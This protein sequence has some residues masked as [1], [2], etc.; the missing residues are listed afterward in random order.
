MFLIRLNHQEF[1]QAMM[2]K[3][4]TYKKTEGGKE[5]ESLQKG[6]LKINE[7]GRKRSREPEVVAL[8]NDTQK[9]YLKSQHPIKR[10][11]SGM[12]H[13]YHEKSCHLTK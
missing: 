12:Q 9:R 3:K 13:S 1:W 8:Q 6:C 2:P 11:L 4:Q 7:T 5:K 10:S